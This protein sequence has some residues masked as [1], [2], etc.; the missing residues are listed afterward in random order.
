MEPEPQDAPS[1]VH[2]TV[3]LCGNDPDVESAVITMLK[4]TGSPGCGEEGFKETDRT[5][6]SVETPAEPVTEKVLSPNA[7]PPPL[8]EIRPPA[9]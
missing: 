5:A 8:R 9:M 7:T 3:M 4:I 6:Q 2:C 1:I